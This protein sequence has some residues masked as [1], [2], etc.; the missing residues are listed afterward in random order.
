MPP[1][2]ANAFPP[3]NGWDQIVTTFGDIRK[4]ILG[5]GTIDVAWE[6]VLTAVVLPQP[7]PLSWDFK[8]RVS[9][10]RCHRVMAVPLGAVFFELHHRGL[11]KELHEYGGCYEFRTQRGSAEKLS[12]HAFGAAIDLNP[13]TNQQGRRGDIQ[14]SVVAV[15]EAHGFTWGGRWTRPDPMHFQFASGY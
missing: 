14:P 9:R 4:F 15:F 5:D 8:T 1:S 6:Q 13:S 11:W 7:L 12:L 10:V 3:P 2:S